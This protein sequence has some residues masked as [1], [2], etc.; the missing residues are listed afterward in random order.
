MIAIKKISVRFR[1]NTFFK[2]VLEPKEKFRIIVH[3]FLG[4]VQ[5]YE[6]F[7]LNPNLFHLWLNKITFGYHKSLMF[8]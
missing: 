6:Y 5:V 7:L 4:Y 2:L 1:I 8:N 3:L